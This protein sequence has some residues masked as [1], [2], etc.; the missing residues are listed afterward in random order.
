MLSPFGHCVRGR[1]LP[2]DFTEFL[3]VNILFAFTLARQSTYDS[4]TSDKKRPVS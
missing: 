1:S 4:G 2:H 3:Y